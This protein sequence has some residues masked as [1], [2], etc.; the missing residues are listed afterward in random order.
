MKSN[1]PKIIKN[2][3]K[4]AF[5][6]QGISLF[7]VETALEQDLKEGNFNRTGVLF[8]KAEGVLG[9]VFNAA[10]TAVLLSALAGI[11]VAGG[12]LLNEENLSS[13]DKRISDK[14]NKIKKQKKIME[15][16]KNEYGLR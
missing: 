13:Q 1:H 10:E 7:D 15:A 3:Y 2:L 5:E 4:I 6:K 9:G 8:K 11:G 12:A 16:L 14:V